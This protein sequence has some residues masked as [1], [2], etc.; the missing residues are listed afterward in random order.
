MLKRLYRVPD[1]T[2]RWVSH[3]QEELLGVLKEGKVDA[4]VLIDQ[5][6]FRGEKD[7]EVRCLYTDGQGWKQLYGFDEMIKHMIAIRE[8]LL[9]EHPEL[10]EKLLRAFKASFRYSEE[11]LDEIATE[12]IAGYGGEREA[13]IASARY[14]RIEFT[15]TETE[16]KIAEDEMEML[17]ETGYIPRKIPLS[18]AFAV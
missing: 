2:L 16:R 15:F 12:F 13:L 8:P 14:P 9:K 5:F 17:V 1:G 10:R 4:V 18:S 7:P 6:F 3:P 11:H